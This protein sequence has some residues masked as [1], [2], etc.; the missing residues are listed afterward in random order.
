MAELGNT[1]LEVLAGVALGASIGHAGQMLI[2][3]FKPDA[4]TIKN[5]AATALGMEFSSLCLRL[6]VESWALQQ[7]SN[8]LLPN[9]ID[10]ASVL[11]FLT[12]FFIDPKIQ[13]N[14]KRVRMHMHR[15]M[16][17]TPADNPPAPGS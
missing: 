14:I 2:P 5:S 8:Y 4:D 3:D 11:A 16:T 9:G 15:M 6:G 7:A 13:N 12:M 17:P 1:V 10:R